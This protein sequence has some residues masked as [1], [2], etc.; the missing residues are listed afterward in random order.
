[1]VEHDAVRSEGE[2]VHHPRCPEGQVGG[3]GH[4][5]VDLDHVADPAV[6]PV[7][8]GLGLQPLRARHR[9]TQLLLSLADRLLHVLET[10]AQLQIVVHGILEEAQEQPALAPFVEELRV[11]DHEGRHTPGLVVLTD[12][13]CER[14]QVVARHRVGDRIGLAVHPAGVVVDPEDV[15]VLG[16]PDR[17]H[18]LDLEAGGAGG[19]HRVPPLE[20]SPEGPLDQRVQLLLA[21]VILVPHR[22]GERQPHLA[23][24]PVPVLVGDPAP[25]LDQLQKT[26][27]GA[28]GPG[29]LVGR[30]PATGV[31]GSREDQASLL[32]QPRQC[33]GLLEPPEESVVG[34]EDLVEK[35]LPDL[36]GDLAPA[37]RAYRRG[38]SPV[39][40]L[41]VVAA[42]LDE[43]VPLRMA[44]VRLVECALHPLELAAKGLHGTLVA[45]LVLVGEQVGVDDEPSPRVT[46]VLEGVLR[47]LGQ[48]Q[49]RRRRPLR[50]GH[51]SP[52]RARL[53]HVGL[54]GDLEPN[55]DRVTPGRDPLNSEAAP[56]PEEPAAPEV[57]RVGDDE[58][59]P[60]HLG[61]VVD[62]E[63]EE[64]QAARQEEATSPVPLAAGPPEVPL[65]RDPQPSRDREDQVLVESGDP[66]APGLVGLPVPG[67]LAGEVRL[68]ER[69]L[70]HRLDL[71]RRT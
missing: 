20:R 1:M 58:V 16:R 69:R 21:I 13:P 9:L 32:R 64:E 34:E 12:A 26:V 39:D 61:V 31:E 43:G 65:G 8:P 27:V 52:P 23:L 35:D 24:V 50:Q 56:G 63:V 3:E 17:P 41:V 33:V 38:E 10:L 18:E 71:L 57:R 68:D 29:P 40:R 59:R 14:L 49:G 42:L 54:E 28:Q 44:L 2:K 19:K 36:V 15:V 22:E 4:A 47:G 48:A 55:V 7:A 67:V 30:E 5:H 45:P 66:D 25:V 11:E 6:A 60:L 62:A 53:P 37:L 70:P 46:H 51:V